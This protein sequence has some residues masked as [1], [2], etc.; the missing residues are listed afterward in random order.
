MV[1][2]WGKVRDPHQG[3]CMAISLSCFAETENTAGQKKL[4][5][6]CPKACRPQTG[7]KLKV[8]STDLI[9]LTVHELIM[10]SLNHYYK[11]PHYPLQGGT[12]F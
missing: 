4:T 6:C 2:P 12:Q 10:T 8:D 3:I 9:L 1:Q 5:V 7:W 11:T